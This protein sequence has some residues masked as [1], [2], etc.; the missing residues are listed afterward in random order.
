M[1]EGAEVTK[2]GTSVKGIWFPTTKEIIIDV[3]DHAPGKPEQIYRGYLN[4]EGNLLVDKIQIYPQGS[5]IIN[6]LGPTVLKKVY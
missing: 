1:G 5:Y 6:D 2:A 3:G 4:A